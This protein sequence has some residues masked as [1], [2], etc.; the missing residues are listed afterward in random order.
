LCHPNIMQIFQR[1]VLFDDVDVA[2]DF[3]KEYAHNFGFYVRISQ[4]R[5]DDN[6]VV[7]WKRFCAL[8]R[9]VVLRKLNPMILLKRCRELERV[10]MNLKLIY[11]SN[12]P[13]KASMKLKYCMRD[14]TMPL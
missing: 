14:I 3:Y 2:H 6:G 4:Q 1:G 10:D 11:M 8:E 7:Q 5:H 12:I 13:V 9:V